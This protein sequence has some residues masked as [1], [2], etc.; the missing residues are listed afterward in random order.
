MTWVAEQF[1]LTS[2]NRGSWLRPV[3]KGDPSPASTTCTA[4]GDRGDS[5]EQGLGALRDSG[6][7]VTC[8]LPRGRGVESVPIDRQALPPGAR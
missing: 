4:P 1:L 7:A 6:R 8:P 5:P 2:S 3:E